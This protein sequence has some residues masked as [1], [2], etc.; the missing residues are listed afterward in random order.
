[1][2]TNQHKSEGLWGVEQLTLR[3]LILGALGAAVITA[4]SMYTAL[5]LGALPWPTIFVAVL[6]MTVLK[7]LGQTNLKEISIAQT[8]MSARAMVAGDDI[9][10]P[11]LITGCG[12]GRMSW[13]NT[14]GRYSPLRWLG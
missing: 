14:G 7:L 11:T 10:L 12:Q 6:S 2:K 9:T 1:M 8:A 13:L 3:S 5:R 4:S